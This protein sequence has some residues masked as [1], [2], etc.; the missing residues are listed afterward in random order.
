M[1]ETRRRH[2]GLGVRGQVD[3]Q[4]VAFCFL[5]EVC[6]GR[7]CYLAV[8]D[9]PLVLEYVDAVQRVITLR[10]T[11]I[12]SVCL[13]L[14]CCPSSASL[15]GSTRAFALGRRSETQLWISKQMYSATEQRKCI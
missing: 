2:V 13:P 9:A 14:N 3:G 10:T 11:L 1:V 15:R 8:A 6:A 4:V 7:G 5:E 12:P